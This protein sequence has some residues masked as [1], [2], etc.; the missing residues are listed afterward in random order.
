MLMSNIIKF[1]NT[2]NRNGVYRD[3]LHWNVKQQDVMD[4]LLQ[5]NQAAERQHTNNN[6]SKNNKRWTHRKN[7]RSVRYKKK[8]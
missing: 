8:Q 6:N 7:V 4:T 1:V 3:G 5:D 2:C